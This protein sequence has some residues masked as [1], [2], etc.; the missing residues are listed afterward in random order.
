MPLRLLIYILIIAASIETIAWGAVE[1][2]YPP[3][4]SVVTAP[5]H[6]ILK[7]NQIDATSLRIT[8][9]GVVG[10]PVEVGS[11]EYRKLFHDYFIAQ[12][13]W[14]P[15]VNRMVVDLFNGGQKIESAGISV[16][17]APEG[18]DQ[19]PPPEYTTTTLHRPEK[20][21]LCQPCHVMNPTPA[22]MNSS[23]EK[24]NPC[25]ICHKKMLAVKYVHGPAGTYSCGYCHS[26]KGSPKHAVPKRGAALCYECHAD[27]AVQVKKKKFI[28]GPIEAGMCDACHDPHGSDNEGQLLKPINEIC[29]SCHGHIRGQVHVVRVSGGET[30]PL[31]GKVDPSKQGSGRQMSCISCHSPHGGNV[32]YFFTNNA[33]D[34]MTLCQVCHNK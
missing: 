14:D 30:H 7:F 23:V 24:N 26:S 1:F 18:A 8:H 19:K 22:Q 27:M 6:L 20:E 29:L 11:P 12:A 32:R 4:S 2:I 10:D 15:A 13:L 3:Q 31:S 9:N 17:Y 34:R 33:E 25:Y 28:H 16:F 21:L 5:G